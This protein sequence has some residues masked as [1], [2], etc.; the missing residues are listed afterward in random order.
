MFKIYF[1]YSW[2]KIKNLLFLFFI[3]LIS[4]ATSLRLKNDEYLLTFDIYAI[5]LIITSILLSAIGLVSLR[6]N[7]EY[8]TLAEIQKRLYVIAGFVPIIIFASSM[9]VA[10]FDQSLA[11]FTWIIIIPVQIFLNKKIYSF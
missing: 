1:G 6:A 4:F 7:R 2:Q 5:I 8:E 9:G 3:T 10:R 11:Q